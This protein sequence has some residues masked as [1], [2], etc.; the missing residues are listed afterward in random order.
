MSAFAERAYRE[1]ALDT[2]LGRLNLKVPKLRQGTM[3]AA[4]RT[5]ADTPFTNLKVRQ[6]VA[7]AIDRQAIVA[8]LFKSKSQVVSS[9]CFP[10]Q[11]GCEQDVTSYDYD[12]E[13][14]RAL[15]AKAGYRRRDGNAA[16]RAGTVQAQTP[17]RHQT[18]HADRDTQSPRRGNDCR[19]CQGCKLAI[20]HD[21]RCHIGRV[22]KRL[23]LTTTSEKV[24]ERGRV[25]RIAS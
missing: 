23:G 19:D 17:S 3:D 12:P 1:R 21:S 25:Y 10:S 15:L 22:E 18:G 6:A 11:F 13:K 24:A 14:A 4:G 2:R 7:H 20:T 5:G 16:A 9:A 8:V